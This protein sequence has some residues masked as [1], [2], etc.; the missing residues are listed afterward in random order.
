VNI[1]FLQDKTGLG[2]HLCLNYNVDL[3]LPDR[4]TGNLFPGQKGQEG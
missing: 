3:N 4:K 2:D 1:L